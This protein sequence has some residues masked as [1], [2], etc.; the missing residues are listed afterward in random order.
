MTR[1]RHEDFVR[2]G[3][4]E[5]RELQGEHWEM[6]WGILGGFCPTFREAFSFVRAS[7]FPWSSATA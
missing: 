6:I 4:F 5:R 2:H 7:A 3:S 1:N